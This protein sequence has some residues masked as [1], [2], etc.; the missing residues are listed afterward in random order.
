MYDSRGTDHLGDYERGV[1]IRHY[2]TVGVVGIVGKWWKEQL[3]LPDKPGESFVHHIA[4]H[5]TLLAT[6]PRYNRLS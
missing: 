6:L 5:P 1:K 4:P 3:R 2:T